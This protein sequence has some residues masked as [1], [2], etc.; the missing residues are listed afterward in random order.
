MKTTLAS[1]LFLA[2]A[3]VTAA[4]AQA[5]LE[6]IPDN[7]KAVEQPDSPVQLSIDGIYPT[8]S[9][10]KLFGYTVRN[11]GV[12]EIRS[13][14]ILNDREGTVSHFFLGLPGT[15][16]GQLGFGRGLA[17]GAAK[18]LS[19]PVTGYDQTS[20]GHKLSVD[21]VLFRDGTSWGPDKFGESERLLGALDG[22][23]RFIAEVRKLLAAKDD[24]ELRALIMRD[25]PP[26]DL[27][28]V[29]METRT[30]RQLGATN[31]YFAARIAFR[32]DLEGR[33][34]LTGV[35]ARIRDAD[36]YLGHS[37]AD[38]KSKQISIQYSFNAPIKFI[39]I[40]R[41]GRDLNFDDRFAA[42]G[43]WL[44]GT[45][46]RLKNEYGKAIRSVSLGISFPEAINSGSPMVSNLRYG[47]HP[48]T[49]VENVRQPRVGPGQLFEIV[50]DEDRPGSLMRFLKSRQDIN[51][52]S[53]AVLD[54]SYIDFEDGTR[55]SG[56]QWQKQDPKDSKRWVPLTRES[57]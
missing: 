41:G 31:G 44:S 16:A 45:R 32:A 19:H 47:P 2:L 46:L 26:P 36:R 20:R 23:E 5:K 11:T 7:I 57:K 18:T 6:P 27:S 10:Y 37:D 30:K 25:G 3:A 14:I 34:N 9:N 52:I 51:T 40:S 48:V 29:A 38:D 53:L 49:Q 43:D 56:G 28:N 22:Y 17:G 39:G 35:P 12:K 24:A 15:M 1:I 4:Q 42:D 33:G 21:F 8:P 54:I 13:I 50:I 55:W